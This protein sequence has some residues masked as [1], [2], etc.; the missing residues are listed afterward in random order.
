MDIE[1]LL[2]M[3]VDMSDAE[4][5]RWHSLPEGERARLLFELIDA[6]R[7][8]VLVMDRM[9]RPDG[10]AHDGHR[11]AQLTLDP[12]LVAKVFPQL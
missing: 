2:R 8:L 3:R 9:K 1:S 10:P 6:V 5:A 12:E 7:R 4:A 11:W